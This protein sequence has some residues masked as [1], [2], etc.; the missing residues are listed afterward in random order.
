MDHLKEYDEDA[1]KYLVE[2]SISERQWTLLHDG[3]HRYAVANTNMSEAFNGVMKGARCLTITSS[4]R[5]VSYRV[6]IYFAKRRDLGRK[7]LEND[8]VYAKKPID[9][10]DKNID[11]A[12]FHDVR[13]Y[14]TVCRI[15]EVITSC[16]N[17]V[18]GKGGKSYIVD[19]TSTLRS[20]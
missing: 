16:G 9:M 13:I 17:R 18:A 12:Q 15:F 20:C 1:Y 4:V 7:R 19:S 11:K 10:I 8:H 3:A 5:M 2:G 14:D 6:N